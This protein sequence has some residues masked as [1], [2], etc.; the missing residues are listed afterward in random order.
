[1]VLDIGFDVVGIILLFLLIA[2]IIR[3]IKKGELGNPFK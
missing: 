3:G 2:S 1:M